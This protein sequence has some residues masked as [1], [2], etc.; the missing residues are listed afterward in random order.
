M[1]VHVKND[2]MNIVKKKNVRIA[3]L[4]TDH[5]FNNATQS[6][7]DDAMQLIFFLF[8]SKL[9]VQTFNQT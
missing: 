4:L 1:T 9:Y 8:L 2:T 6:S 3:A 7:V 5:I